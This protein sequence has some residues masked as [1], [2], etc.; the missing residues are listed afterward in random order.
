MERNKA[1]TPR[2]SNSEL[3]DLIERIRQ[4]LEPMELE[5]KVLALNRIR[6]ELSKSSPFSD[7]VDYVL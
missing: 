4:L 1:N 3:D 5:E 2:N 6:E 7:P